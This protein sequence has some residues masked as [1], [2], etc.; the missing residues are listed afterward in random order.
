M[1]ILSAALAALL[2]AG[3]ALASPPPEAVA[4]KEAGNH[5][6]KSREFEKARDQYLA[7]LKLDPNYEDAH[8]N[9][10]VVYFFRLQD[11]S[12]ALYHF[13]RYAGIRPDASDLGQVKGLVGQS[14]EKIE[15]EER[16]LYASALAQGG[17]PALEAFSS[18]HAVGYYAQ[19]AREK[20]S[21]LDAYEAA[22]AERE[23]AA[24]TA[25][26]EASTRRT[27]DA[28]EGFLATYP[29]SQKEPEARRLLEA[30][31]GEAAGQ[32]ARLEAERKAKE[33]AEQKARLEAERKAREEAEQKARLEAERKAR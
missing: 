11:Y 29:A 24:A 13:T 10:G 7:A 32:K 8:Y 15:A 33:E 6:L 9:L 4:R 20:L 31:R 1:R 14:L 26:Q 17:R 21:R 18:A 5:F 16:D 23:R 19:D 22:V 25:F 27:T 28:L 12:R 3:A 2:G 30:L